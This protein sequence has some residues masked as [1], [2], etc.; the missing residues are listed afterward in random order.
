MVLFIFMVTAAAL[1]LLFYLVY[2]LKA[3]DSGVKRAITAR[4]M[5]AARSNTKFAGLISYY[6]E[7]LPAG[8]WDKKDNPNR[9]Y[10]YFKTHSYLY[11]MQ[12]VGFDG[13]EKVRYNRLPPPAQ[14]EK[15]TGNKLQYIGKRHYFEEIKKMRTGTYYISHLVPH[16][17][18]GTVELP[19]KWMLRM[20]AK[21]SEYIYIINLNLT[22][23][24]NDFKEKRVVFISVNKKF[25]SDDKLS[26]VLKQDFDK[27]AQNVCVKPIKYKKFQVGYLFFPGFTKE[28]LKIQKQFKQELF[29]FFI[30]IIIVVIMIFTALRYL[31]IIEKLITLDPLTKIGNRHS[32]E[33]KLKECFALQKRTGTK[34]GLLLI[35]ID[36]F[37]N[38]NDDYGHDFGDEVLKQTTE[39]IK[40]SISPYD[41]FGRWGG[42]EFIVICKNLNEAELKSVASRIHKS[43]P[44]KIFMKG[45]DSVKVTVSVGGTISNDSDDGNSVLKKADI[46]L[47]NCKEAGKDRIFIG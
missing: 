11:Q 47:Y 25:I 10:A 39:T 41:F 28:F 7:K 1:F 5:I 40:N 35:D 20:A 4:E 2:L 24:I 19:Y 6:L 27:T 45:R 33:S 34:S 44:G 43:V 38:I 22:S 14:V 16:I 31:T 30:T 9:M 13:Y 37:K 42:D 32:I 15:V 17:E 36:Y 21:G 3:K 18:K 46:N 29:I 23:Y 26:W 12:T 8:F